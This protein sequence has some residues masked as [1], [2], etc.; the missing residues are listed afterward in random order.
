MNTYCKFSLGVLRCTIVACEN[1]ST[2]NEIKQ[3]VGI[4]DF[5]AGR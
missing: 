1:V 4:N 5:E 2:Y 3:I